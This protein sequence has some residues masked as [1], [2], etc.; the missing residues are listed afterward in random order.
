[1]SGLPGR[2]PAS[3]SL[4]DSSAGDLPGPATRSHTPMPG[5]VS[6]TTPSQG[7]WA[8]VVAGKDAGQ[9]TTATPQ[10]TSPGTAGLPVGVRKD[11]PGR[12]PA[13]SPVKKV[14]KRQKG[15]QRSQTARSK[16]TTIEEVMQF[17]GCKSSLIAHL[18]RA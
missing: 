4:K 13:S 17:S 11:V 5:S 12:R 15:S 1:M 14:V 16:A 3:A 6:A 10:V 18:C 9:I 7:R 2:P 8:D